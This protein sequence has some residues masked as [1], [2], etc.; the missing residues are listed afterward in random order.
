VG[1]SYDNWSTK[2][3]VTNWK[4]SPIP[5]VGT[6]TT[7]RVIGEDAGPD[8]VGTVDFSDDSTPLVADL[9]AIR[10][11]VFVAIP[12]GILETEEVPAHPGACHKAGDPDCAPDEVETVMR[13]TGIRLYQSINF[14]TWDLVFDSL[15]GDGPDPDWPWQA[16][17]TLATLPDPSGHG[18]RVVLMWREADGSNRVRMRGT[19]ATVASSGEITVADQRASRGRTGRARRPDPTSRGPPRTGRVTT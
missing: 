8:H 9:A 12:Y 1:S 18:G 17:P 10:P 14:E 7:R 19:I 6:L 5:A 15:V 2:Q 11:I 13:Y 4:L 16:Q 3:R